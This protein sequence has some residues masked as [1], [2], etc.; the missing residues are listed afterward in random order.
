MDPALLLNYKK[1][2]FSNYELNYS[3][4]EVY[5][6]NYFKN[7]HYIGSMFN[8]P[9]ANSLDKLTSLTHLTFGFWF[10]QTLDDSL[11]KLT[12]LTHLI[13]GCLFNNPLAN[14]LDKLTSLTH[15][16]FGSKFN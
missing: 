12:S 16:T 11:N 6:N 4:F 5:E 15:L 14:S 7:L 1:I 10:N 9:L 13:F 3:L 8:Q 2:I